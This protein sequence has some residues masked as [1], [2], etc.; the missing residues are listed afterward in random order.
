MI[1]AMTLT[2]GIQIAS[3]A[4]AALAAGAAWVAARAT[5]D[6][7]RA[8]RAGNLVQAHAMRL[9]ALRKIH[10]DISWLRQ[11][12]RDRPQ[13][14]AAGPGMPAR[15]LVH[16]YQACHPRSGPGPEPSSARLTVPSE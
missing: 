10:T 1:L 13:R 15:D 8:T 9:D 7:A 14:Q 12:G 11:D 16:E 5:R 4:L 6:S 3:T 2:D